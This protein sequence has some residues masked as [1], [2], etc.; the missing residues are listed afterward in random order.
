[1]LARTR[2]M[3]FAW[4]GS[5]SDHASSIGVERGD[6]RVRA[7]GLVMDWETIRTGVT[8]AA[9]V[10]G[11]VLLLRAIRTKP[12]PKLTRQ[13]GRPVTGRGPGMAI[14]LII[15][16]VVLGFAGACNLVSGSQ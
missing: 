7:G 16:G 2:Q 8:A 3:A 5:R 15:L 4:M 13:Y 1:V 10:G 9:F 14:F 11:G 12:D 6:G